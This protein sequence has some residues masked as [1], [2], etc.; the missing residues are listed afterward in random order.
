MSENGK[1]KLPLIAVLGGT[2]KEGSGL[3]M[4]WA[5]A[6]YPIIIGSRQQDRAKATADELNGLLALDTIRGMDNAA[7][8]QAA[9]ICILTVVQS[10]H[11]E[12]ILGLKAHLQGKILV[13]ATARVDFKDARPPM[14]PAAARYAQNLLGPGVRVVAAFQNVSANL[15][16]KNLDQ[17]LNTDVLVCADDLEA[18]QQVIGLALAA[19]MRAFYA[20]DL[21]NAV[22][23]EGL[24][25]VLI[26]LNKYYGTRAATIN[27]TGLSGKSSGGFPVKKA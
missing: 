14:P 25:A 13:D 15:L 10:A 24:T 22:V 27:V 20:G 23:V 21:D 7:A 6:G 16:K 19:G 4:R 8:A 1:P 11:Q 9:D 2:G 18:A 5:H 3:A 12:A 26:T 17:P